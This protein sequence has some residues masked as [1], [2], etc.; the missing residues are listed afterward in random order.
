MV[1]VGQIYQFVV[2]SARSV[3]Q[4][5]IFV[6]GRDVANG[7]VEVYVKTHKEK[8]HLRIKKHVQSKRLRY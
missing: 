3:F 4:C 7:S 2:P 8:T 6:L 1:S 5:V